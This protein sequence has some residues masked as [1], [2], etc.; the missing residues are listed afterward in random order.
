MSAVSRTARAGL[1]A[2]VTYPRA[3]EEECTAC[4]LL[5]IDSVGLVRGRDRKR[6]RTEVTLAQNVNDRPYVASSFLSVAIAQVLGS[7]LRGSSKER[8][9]LAATAIPLRAELSVV[10][11][12][13]GEGLF[14]RLFEPVPIE[15]SILR[16]THATD[17]RNP[18]RAKRERATTAD[19]WSGF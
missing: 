16:P 18:S 2:R 5:D 8:P 15:I 17:F 4:L 1:S 11:C 19:S 12:R 6:S 10:P 13:G 7:A 3:D 14:R 9:E